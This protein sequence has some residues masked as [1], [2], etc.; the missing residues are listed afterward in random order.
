MAYTCPVC[1]YSDL[2]TPP[3]NDGAPSFEI[4]PSCGIQFGYT[5]AAGGDPEARTALWKKWRR[6]WIE[7]GMAWN[8]I[9]QKPPSG[10]DPVAQLKNIGIAI[11][12]PTDTG[13]AC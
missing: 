10:W 7:T 1:G 12:R 5:D 13:S 4:C 2:S 6:R 8:S 9:G 11:D 3:W